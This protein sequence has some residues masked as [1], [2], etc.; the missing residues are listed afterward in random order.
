MAAEFRLLGDNEARAE[1]R[2]VDLGHRR[3]RSVLVILLVEANRVVTAD[4]LV[5]RMWAG[6]PPQ[7]ARSTLC[8]YVHRL[9]KA[10]SGMPGADIVRQPGGYLL[11]VDE[12]LIEMCRF[13]ELSRRAA[14]PPTTR[15]PWRCSARRWRCGGENSL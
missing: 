4:Q 7:R 3:P 9:R 1:G 11:A 13:R 15:R 8:G 2:L 5:K 6:Q 14:P 12:D 10:L